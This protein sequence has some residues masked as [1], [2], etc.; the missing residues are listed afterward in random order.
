MSGTEDILSS[1]AGPLVQ[2]PFSSILV[3][4]Q[5][6]S[7]HR[8]GES[9]FSRSPKYPEVPA[10]VPDTGCPLTQRAAASSVPG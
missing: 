10:P 9:L 7:L 2:M 5:H 1:P 8:L 4:P 6:D 3:D